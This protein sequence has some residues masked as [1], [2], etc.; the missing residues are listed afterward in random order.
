M[1]IELKNKNLDLSLNE[2][3]GKV[4]LSEIVFDE[5]NFIKCGKNIFNSYVY[6]FGSGYRGKQFN[7]YCKRGETLTY[8]CHE[9]RSEKFGKTL[10][11]T[12]RN[13]K[14]EVTTFYN[15]Y[16]EFTVLEAKKQVKN[17]SDKEITLEC[18]SP[19]CF[20]V[21]LNGGK[22]F[23]VFYKPH[24][25]WCCEFN[26]EKVN[27]NGGEFAPFTVADTSAKTSVS[28]DGTQT[29]NKYL[30]V[31]F[32]ET[33]D[34]G[35]L[36]FEISPSGSWS[37]E[38]DTV[39]E[40]EEKNL[41]VGLTGRTHADNFW[42]KKLLPGEAYETESVRL[43]GGKDIDA[44]IKNLTLYRR[45]V[46][47]KFKINAY[48][49]VI[50]NNFMHN[51]YDNPTEES[52][53][54]HSACAEKCGADYYVVDAG[55]HDARVNGISPTQAIG[56]WYTENV[57]NYPSGFIKTVDKI[58]SLGMKFGLWVEL[59]S[60]GVYCDTP[61][62][63]SED[64]FFHIDGVR[65]VCNNR[66]Q[67]DFNNPKVRDY[68][69]EVIAALV[70][71]YS[72]DYIKI[73]YNQTALGNDCDCGSVTEGLRLHYKAYE[74][75]FIKLQNDY[76][77]IIFETCSSGGMR[78]SPDTGK[79]SNVISVSDQSNYLVYPYILAN[80]AAALLPE[81]T[82]VWNI[83]VKLSDNPT[84]DNEEIVMN[85][86]NSFYGVMH[87][88]GRLNNLNEQQAALLKEGVNYYR[89]LIKIKSEAIPV[90]PDGF[91]PYGAKE[92]C[93]GLS[94]EE[95]LYLFIYNL[96]DNVKTIRRDLSKYGAVSAT[97]VFPGYAKNAISFDKGIL[98]TEMLAK[99]ARV[100]ELS[101]K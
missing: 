13:E 37:Y 10:I 89:S 73:D 78:N 11:V 52:D 28:S 33:K 6:L 20:S 59:Q 15:V 56:K 94:T 32:L 4:Y 26:Y 48:E 76:P 84:T 49:S 9:E 86:I 58:R 44:V 29:T 92:I 88:A 101:K 96:S 8:V 63:L 53:A 7:R 91:V 87:L 43:T 40:G 14:I 22:D 85:C 81:Q 68:A 100:I 42:Y 50:Y 55:W 62:L 38:I 17:I 30:P 12:E 75:W 19:F 77:D 21:P 2:T 98:K 24:N 95:K 39:C 45:A 64:C 66:Y 57:S 1:N 23:P 34:C 70:K 25:T 71:K 46:R 65:P 67:L 51:T 18:V 36:A 41:F 80:A 82:G 74:D 31:G 93:F 5:K 97:V 27:L 16:D 72:P 60:F 79:I 99:S 54:V 3:D 83:P 47:S 90:M 61:D 69:S 35:F